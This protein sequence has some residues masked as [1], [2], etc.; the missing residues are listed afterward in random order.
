MK[1]VW[2][3][4]AYAISL[5]NNWLIDGG[6]RSLSIYSEMICR[7][8]PDAPVDDKTINRLKE[9]VDWLEKY[10]DDMNSAYWGGQE[11]VLITGNQAKEILQR[12]K[13]V[14]P[15]PE[16]EVH[17]RYI[18]DALLPYFLGIRGGDI[19][20]IDNYFKHKSLGIRSIYNFLKGL[21]R[22]SYLRPVTPD[23]IEEMNRRNKIED[24]Y[25]SV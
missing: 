9:Q 8:S 6:G 7:L 19:S 17:S 20:G 25:E 23:M 2:E 3:E 10:D 24:D 12:L 22:A 16:L 21:H 14:E 5:Y 18:E 1:D 13:P 15:L 11:G 4:V